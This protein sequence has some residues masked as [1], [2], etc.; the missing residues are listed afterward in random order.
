MCTETLCVQNHVCI[1]QIT[2]KDSYVFFYY[3]Y[4]TWNTLQPWL[5]WPLWII[6][7][8]N[9]Q[10]YVTLVVNSSRSFPHSWLINGCVTRLTRRMPRM[11]QELL[12]L[13][14]HL[15]SPPVLVG[16]LVLNLNLYVYVLQ[17][18]ACSFCP[19]SFGFCVICPS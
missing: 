14:E 10:G 12:T 3:Y 18:V 7:V 5:G 2:T 19:L 16:F 13:P 4:T 17:I 9:E 15:S 11:E 6:C 1:K 8:P